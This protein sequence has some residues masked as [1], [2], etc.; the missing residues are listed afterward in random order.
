MHRWVLLARRL[1]RPALD[2]SL[3]PCQRLDLD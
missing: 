1:Y 3:A 2:P